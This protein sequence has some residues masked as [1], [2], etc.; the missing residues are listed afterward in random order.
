MLILKSRTPAAWNR[1]HRSRLSRTIPL[2]ISVGCR[3]IRAI[4]HE[5]EDFRIQRRSPPSMSIDVFP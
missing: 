2:V 4:A 5:L 3:P 1:R